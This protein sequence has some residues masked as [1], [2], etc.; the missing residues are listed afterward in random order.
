M[1]LEEGLQTIAGLL[2]AGG[3]GAAITRWLTLR[4]KREESVDH[5]FERLIDE[6]QAQLQRAHDA[7]DRLQARVDEL[8]RAQAQDAARLAELER[9]VADQRREIGRLAQLACQTETCDRR[10]EQH[11]TSHS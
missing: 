9:V 8:T 10:R 6:L 11:A 4:N 3:L 5:R 1:K 2:G 7:A